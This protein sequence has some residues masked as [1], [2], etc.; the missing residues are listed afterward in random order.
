[1][2]AKN[3]KDV[4]LDETAHILFDAVGMLKADPALATAVLPYGGKFSM[5][6]PAMPVA[7]AS[8]ARPPAGR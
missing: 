8:V 4:P 3:A 1:K 5:A 7:A 2:D 6:T